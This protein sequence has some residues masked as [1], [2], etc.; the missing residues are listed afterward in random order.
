MLWCI[1]IIFRALLN[2]T[3]T[4]YKVALLLNTW[5]FVHRIFF[6]VEKFYLNVSK[7][8]GCIVWTDNT[9]KVLQLFVNAHKFIINLNFIP[10]V[11]AVQCVSWLTR[12]RW[13]VLVTSPE[14][15]ATTSLNHIAS[16][17]KASSRTEEQRACHFALIFINGMPDITQV[18]HRNEVD[19]RLFADVNSR[20]TADTASNASMFVNMCTNFWMHSLNVHRQTCSITANDVRNTSTIA[21]VQK[22]EWRFVRLILL[23]RHQFQARISAN[24]N[25][26]WKLSAWGCENKW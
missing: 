5:K 4:I 18:L 12:M 14:N 13:V 1:L 24:S 6:G 16:G 21:H 26:M 10:P 2:I 8:V 25:L 23:W 7:H 11:G 20:K 17:A 15:T 19:N 3:K 9:K 22:Y